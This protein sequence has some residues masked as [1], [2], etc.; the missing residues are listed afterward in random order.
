MSAARDAWLDALTQA[1]EADARSSGI[2][3]DDLRA[4]AEHVFDLLCVD[5]IPSMEYEGTQ[6]APAPWPDPEGVLTIFF[7]RV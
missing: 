1:A 2:P 7:G 6:E 3:Y 5:L 4:V